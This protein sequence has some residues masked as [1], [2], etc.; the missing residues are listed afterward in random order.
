MCALYLFSIVFSYCSKESEYNHHNR[1]F[2]IIIILFDVELAKNK[3]FNYL[4]LEWCKK[5]N[6]PIRICSVDN[7]I[8]KS[9]KKMQK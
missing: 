2:F 9:T 8:C 4:I 7:R 5:G 3:H 6:N 1:G